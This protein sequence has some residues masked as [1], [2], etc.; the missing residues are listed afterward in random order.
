MIDEDPA[1]L[2]RVKSEAGVSVVSARMARLPSGMA[3]RASRAASIADRCSTSAPPSAFGS[4]TPSGAAA[5]IASRS[6]SASP[7]D[8][9]L[10]RTNSRGRS[11][12]A[13]FSAM[14]AAAR[15]RAFGLSAMAAH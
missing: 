9:A 6:A 14:H 12:A 4:I 5:T 10:I 2:P 15:W 1:K 11:A 7:L 8:R 3:A 13:R